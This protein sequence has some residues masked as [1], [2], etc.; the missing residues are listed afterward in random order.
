MCLFEINKQGINNTC[1][2]YCTGL[3]KTASKLNWITL[4]ICLCGKV[5]DETLMQFSSGKMVRVYYVP[6]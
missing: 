3:M 2:N 4:E 1:Y 5:L 6:F